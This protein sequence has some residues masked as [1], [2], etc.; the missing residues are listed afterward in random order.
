M[1]D[2]R[3]RRAA[4]AGGLTAALLGGTRTAFAATLTSEDQAIVERA[5]TYIQSLTSVQGRFRQID[6]K[7]S[8]SAGVFFLERPGRARFE[9]D[10]PSGLLVVSDGDEVSVYDRRLKSFDQYPLEQTP[11]ALLLGRTSDWRRSIEIVEVQR[12]GGEIAIQA[13]AAG[14]RTPGRLTLLL[15]DTPEMLRGWIIADAQNQKTEVR[16][17]SLRRASRLSPSLFV[18]EAPPASSGVNETRK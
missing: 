9:Y 3:T 18:L 12:R 17:T 14:R 15:T 7:G 4:L 13:E 6:S 8:Q 16:L 1:P 5:L 2:L 10:P 11:L